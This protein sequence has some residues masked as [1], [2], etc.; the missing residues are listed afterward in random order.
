MGAVQS[1]CRFQSDQIC[2]KV[3]YNVPKIGVS[4]A[5]YLRHVRLTSFIIDT[6]ELKITII[7]FVN[8]NEIISLNL[9]LLLTIISAKSTIKEKLGKW[10][11]K[12]Y[13]LL[14]ILKMKTYAHSKLEVPQENWQLLSDHNNAVGELCSSFASTFLSGEWGRLLGQLHD[15]GKARLSFQGYLARVSGLDDEGYDNGA[16][17]HSG[18][19]AC[20]AVEK[21][22]EMGKIFAYCIAGHHAGLPDWSGGENPNGAL[23]QRLS[24]EKRVLEEVSVKQ[25]EMSMFLPEKIPSK[26]WKMDRNSSDVSFWIRMLYSCLVDADFLDT[27]AFMDSERSEE[28]SKA[29]PSIEVL[30][31]KFF[32]KLKAVELNAAK[33]EVNEIRSQIRLACEKA[34]DDVPGLFSLTV[35]TGG[36]KTLSSTAFAL[37]HALKHGL[38][39]IIYVIPYTSIIEQTADVLRGFFGEENVLEHHSNFDLEKET[40]RSHLSSENWDAPIVVTTSVQFFESLYACKSSRCRKLHNIAGS[41]VILDE[42]QL[43]PL[44]LMLPCAEAIKQL[45]MHYY[46]S[47]VLST[48]TQLNLPGVEPSSVCEIIPSSLDLYHRL[49]R[50]EVEFP[51]DL[52]VR[53]TWEEIATDLT[54]FE[55]VLCIV[56]T[57]RD[58]RE[59]YERMPEGTIHLSAGMCGEHRSKVIA[60]IKRKLADGE[61]IRV[62]STQLVEAGVDIDFPVVYRAFTGLSSVAQ[63]AGRCNREGRLESFG[64]VVV[65]VPPERTPVKD[66]RDSEY[67]LGDLLARPCGVDM[68]EPNV[69]PEFFSALQSRTND[70]GQGFSRML[71]VHIPEEFR[72]GVLSYAEP[73]QYQFREAA[74]AFQMI[75]GAVSVPVIVRYGGNEELIK[76]L[77]DI[78]PKR[79]LMRK[80]QRFTVNLPRSKL[81]ELFEKGMIVELVI[82]GEAHSGV[83]IQTD[84]SAYREDIGFDLFGEGLKSDDFIY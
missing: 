66:L 41:V 9:I 43:L 10:C 11:L 51:A 82:S 73:M 36:G 29:Y 28:R 60:E 80:L 56:N 26:P 15:F 34:A 16:H 65:F 71:G 45:S 62:V 50:T 79:F 44:R 70:S 64:R 59:L 75:D 52:S 38:K 24:D 76:S 46:T 30:A 63:S 22:S 20:L 39:R 57:R 61:S 77:Y 25:Y 35:P 23:V 67:A 53:R 40:P 42:V 14:N 1:N 27:E 2:I 8:R 48:A 69:Y 54:S 13:T 32:R 47:V 58:C 19:G 84:T 68:D 33:T 72:N 55:Q 31:E 49:K 74:A 12:F 18:A 5:G 81:P 6:P 78:G 4:L 83:Y 17:G 21:Y 3:W 7:K 37:R